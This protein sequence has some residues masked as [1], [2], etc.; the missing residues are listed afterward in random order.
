MIKEPYMAKKQSLLRLTH[1][2]YNLPHLLLPSTLDNFLTY[3]DRRN[4]GILDDIED[5][6]EDNEEDSEF[7]EIEMVGTLGYI[8]VNGALTFQPVVGACGEVQGCSYTG[9][10]EQ[11]EDMAEAGAKTIVMEFSSPGGQ[12]SHIWEYANEIRKVCDEHNIEL[13]GYVQEMACSAAYALAC[14]CDEVVSNPDAITGSI[15][16]V[17]ALTD[18]SKAMDDAG[19]KRIYITSGD[20]KVPFAADGSFKKEFLDKI[21]K[22]VNKANEQFASHVSKYTGLSVET[23]KSFNAETFDAE[24]ALDRGLINSIMTQSEFAAYVA[25]KHKVKQTGA[26]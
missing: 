1:S 18:F 17:V 22:D 5:D 24:E 15:G 26:M 2:A 10:L 12:S 21:Q 3:L 23:I 14:L 7:P 4:L 20:A 11:V 16:C 25:A 19:I 8:F 13:I 6:L 9:L